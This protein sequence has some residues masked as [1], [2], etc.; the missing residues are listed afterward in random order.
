MSIEGKKEEILR[1]IAKIGTGSNS[2]ILPLSTGESSREANKALMQ[3]LARRHH[4]LIEVKKKRSQIESNVLEGSFLALFKTLEDRIEALERAIHHPSFGMPASQTH[5]RLEK[6]TLPEPS[7]EPSPEPKSEA[8]PEAMPTSRLDATPAPGE[9]LDPESYL[10]SGKL[11]EGVLADI[12]Q[13][14]SSNMSTGRFA[15]YNK[16]VRIELYYLEGEITHAD[17]A[18]VAGESAFFAAMALEEG[19][20]TF[21]ETTDL[22]SERSIGSKTQF[23]ILEALRQIDE[24][25]AI[26]KEEEPSS[27]MGFEEVFQEK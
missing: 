7:P 27:S 18:G 3:R 2:K 14:L 22:P 15:V 13:L 23:L 24:A 9:S 4:D 19:H 11:K 10:L 8:R 26:D 12:L 5:Q 16:A 25:R 1:L 20:F 21:R 17:G 6:S